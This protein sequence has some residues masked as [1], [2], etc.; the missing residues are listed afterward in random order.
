MIGKVN[1]WNLIRKKKSMHVNKS[2]LS[3]AGV[4]QYNCTIYMMKAELRLLLRS[5]VE[6]L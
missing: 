6:M 4:Q 3:H 5:A 2:H 1:W